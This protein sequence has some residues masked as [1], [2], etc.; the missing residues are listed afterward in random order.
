MKL[1]Q[2]PVLVLPWQLVLVRHRCRQLEL[3]LLWL[4]A[5]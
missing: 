4:Q 1:I 3:L 2:R 5:C